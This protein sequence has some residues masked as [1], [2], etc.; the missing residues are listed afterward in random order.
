MPKQFES[1]GDSTKGRRLDAR[2]HP[3]CFQTKNRPTT[4]VLQ[5]GIRYAVELGAGRTAVA[6]ER[7]LVQE[8]RLPQKVL[9][10][11]PVGHPLL[12]ALQ[13]RGLQEF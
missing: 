12:V 11:L 2:A 7:L 5:E 8:V 13:M 9:R 10:M 4:T 6:R 3:K 1:R